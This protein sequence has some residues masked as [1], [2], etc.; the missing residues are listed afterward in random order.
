[1]PQALHPDVIAALHLMH[2][3]LQDNLGNRLTLDLSNGLVNTIELQL[4]QRLGAPADQTP[5]LPPLGDPS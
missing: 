5:P 3:R 1:M 4:L 2:A